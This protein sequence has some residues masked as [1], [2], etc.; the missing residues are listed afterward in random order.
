MEEIFSESKNGVVLFSF[1]SI[2]D[3][4]KMTEEMKQ[5]FLN[6]FSR[7]P[8]VTF[9][10]KLQVSGNDSH[11]LDPYPNVHVVDWVDQ[12]SILGMQLDDVA[13]H[14]KLKASLAVPHAHA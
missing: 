5:A 9:V 11:L 4:T 10:W 13:S 1:G 6:A 2:A 8:D 3:T 12:V 14:Y 7:F